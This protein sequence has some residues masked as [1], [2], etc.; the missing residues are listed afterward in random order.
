MSLS[1]GPT[2]EAQPGDAP[3]G[4]RPQRHRGWIALSLA[5]LVGIAFLATANFAIEYTNTQEFCVSCHTMQ[6][7]FLE[8][9]ESMHFQNPSGVKATCADC[10]VPKELV[11]KLVV[12]LVAV[13]DV[14]HEVMGTI[15]TPEKFEARRW[16]MA[17]RIWTRMKATDSRECRT[18]HAF[19]DME[20]SAQD[21]TARARHSSAEDKGQTCIDCH[22]GVVHTQPDP[23]EEAAEPQAPADKA[24]GDP[25]P[26]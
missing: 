19:S 7:N 8:Y 14:V 24:S 22:K 17:N 3:T 18:C 11:P 6:T 25:G 1:P 13:K 2:G 20:L 4:A 9:K 12:K 15:D 16:V 23:P 21:R 10:H 26:D 5:F